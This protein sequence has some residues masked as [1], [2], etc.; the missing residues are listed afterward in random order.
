MI[1]YSL[2]LWHWG[3]LTIARWTIGIDSFN[4]GILIALIFIISCF[5][6][7]YIEKPL[8]N[9]NIK[10]IHIFSIGITSIIFGSLSINMLEKFR[11]FLFSGDINLVTEW[12]A[13]DG[14][15]INPTCYT[16]GNGIKNNLE[17]C[18]I[19]YSKT[20]S[21][22]KEFI[23][24]GDSHARAHV[25]LGNHLA[26]KEKGIFRFIRCDNVSFPPLILNKSNKALENY[27]C[28]KRLLDYIVKNLNSNQ[29]II[30][31]ARWQTLFFEDYADLS[32]FS[33]KS[34]HKRGV[35]PNKY[36][37]NSAL[38]SFLN[39][40][41]LLLDKSDEVDA[42]VVILDSLPE[43]SRYRRKPVQEFGSLCSNQWFNKG[44]RSKKP[45]FFEKGFE[46]RNFLLNRKKNFQRDAIIFRK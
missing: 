46:S 40:L 28:G 17:R 19:N 21:D 24:L 2:Y 5:S 39:D 37:S 11:N 3:V 31:S 22:Q 23:L 26:K 4:T 30:L 42:K 14:S 20:N 6:Y 27:E 12:G 8:R 9:L 16:N 33:K 7:E 13:I 36:Y 32:N 25:F 29:V 41:S 44:I 18:S 45:C 34:I 43:F 15:N 10:K 1:S 35:Y 38:S